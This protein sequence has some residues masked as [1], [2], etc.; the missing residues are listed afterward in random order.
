MS[1]SLELKRSYVL[2]A[3]REVEEHDSNACVIVNSFFVK[4]AD[5]SY[6]LS[7]AE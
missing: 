1:F 6:M 4:I 5:T 3:S 2:L 7:T